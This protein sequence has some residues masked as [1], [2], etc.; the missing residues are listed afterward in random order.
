MDIVK[1]N[2]VSIICGVIALIALIVAFVYPLDG[3]ISTLKANAARRAAVQQQVA[4]LVGKPRTVPNFDPSNPVPAK[5]TQFPSNGIIEKARAAVKKVKVQSEQVYETALDINRRGHGL[6]VEGSLPVPVSQPLAI[7]YRSDLQAALD[8]LRLQE[9]VAG[10]PPTDEELK[11]RADALWKQLETGIII[12]SGKPTNLEQVK[13]QYDELVLKLPG[14]MQK[15]MASS[16]KMYVDPATVMKVPASIPSD[17]RSADPVGIWWS[18]VYYWVT[19]DVVSAIKELNGNS[20]NVLKSPV[21]N[22]LALNVPETFF[23]PIDPRNNAVPSDAPTVATGGLPDPTIA[24]PEAPDKS[25][26]K[27]VSN[28]LFDVLHFTLALDIEADAI[29]A[30]LT[31]LSNNRFISVIRFETFPVDSK[32]KQLQGYVYGDKPVMTLVL[33][34]EAVFMRKWTVPWMPPRVKELLSIPDGS[35]GGGSNPRAATN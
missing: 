16:N 11:K 25:P 2:L 5:L 1:K 17:G 18:Q 32:L 30:F 31:A 6:V 12:V 9:L 29:P 20:P 26:T 21:K 3:M 28:N 19:S 14:E 24:V 27:R 13:R 35:G 4:R 15:E 23:P 33:D 8:K 7:R 10:I 34:C 22:L